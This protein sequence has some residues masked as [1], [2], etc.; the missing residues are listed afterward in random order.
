MKFRESGMPS[1]ALWDTFFSPL[2]ILEKMDVD[3]SVD[4]LMDVGCGYGTFLVPASEIVR[5]HVIGIDI[6][7]DMIDICKKKIHEHMLKNVELIHGDICSNNHAEM[8]DSYANKMD[9]ITLFNILHCEEPLK[10]LAR[11]YMLLREGGRIGVIH[12][13][14]E[15]TPRGPSMDIRPKPETIIRWAEQVGFMLRKQIEVPPYHYGLVFEKTRL[16][17]S[18]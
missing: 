18:S 14:Y 17:S 1:E 3:N 11:V 4:N 12:W 5:E 10:L 7:R 13:K 15:D 6:D 2:Q 8:F 9:Y 16:R